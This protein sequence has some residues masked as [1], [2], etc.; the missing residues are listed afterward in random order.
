[1]DFLCFL[2]FVF[3]TLQKRTDKNKMFFQ[4]TEAVGRF[5]LTLSNDILG[6]FMSEQAVRHRT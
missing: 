3:T 6:F 5:L 1:M 4:K 2:P